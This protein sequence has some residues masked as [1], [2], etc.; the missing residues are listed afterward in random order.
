LGLQ[1]Y[2]IP[3]T[4]KIDLYANHRENKSQLLAK[5]IITLNKKMSRVQICPIMF[6]IKGKLITG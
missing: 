5:I 3:A 6:A 2:E 4:E 1:P